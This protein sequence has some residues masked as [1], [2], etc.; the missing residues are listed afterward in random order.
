MRYIVLPRRRKDL[1]RL[2]RQRVQL[3]LTRRPKRERPITIK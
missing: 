2:E 3:T 1:K